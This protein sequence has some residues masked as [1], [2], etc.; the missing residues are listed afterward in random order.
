MDSDGLSDAHDANDD[1]D[2]DDDDDERL[3]TTTG[4]MHD[5]VSLFNR[6]S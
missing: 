4:K 3:M 5:L 6:I 2:D 1:D